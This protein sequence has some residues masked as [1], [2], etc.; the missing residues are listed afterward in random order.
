MFLT[1]KIMIYF[2]LSLVLVWYL[3]RNFS[4]SIELNNRIHEFFSLVL[5]LNSIIIKT[6]PNDSSYQLCLNNQ[7]IV[8][9]YEKTRSLIFV[10][11][12]IHLQKI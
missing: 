10:C 1:I 6:Q 12:H 3:K 4:S 2:N 11:S 9:S 7:N 5:L 8:S